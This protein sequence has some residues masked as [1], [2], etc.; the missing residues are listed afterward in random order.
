[1]EN[2]QQ[3]EFVDALKEAIQPLVELQQKTIQLQLLNTRYS[4]SE[5]SDVLVSLGQLNDQL[6]L[7]EKDEKNKWAITQQNLSH[8]TAIVAR[9][10]YEGAKSV[11]EALRQEIKKIKEDNPLIVN[12]LNLGLY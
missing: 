6:K 9:Q 3:N 2:T 8:D 4:R 12:A 10:D 7:H 1:M 11:T 5:I